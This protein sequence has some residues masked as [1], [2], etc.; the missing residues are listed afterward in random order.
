[1]F[2]IQFYPTPYAIAK[3][4][5]EPYDD[6]IKAGAVVLD[7]SAG[8][9]DLLK[10]AGYLIANDYR[11]K[12]ETKLL[13]VEIDPNLQAVLKQEKFRVIGDDWTKYS[14]HY[15]FDIV[16]MNPP[17]ADGAEHLLLAWERLTAGHIAC[18]LNAQTIKNT[19][20]SERQLLAQIIA[21]N[22][23]TVEYLG[24]CFSSAE[25]RTGVEVALVRLEKK[26]KG[27]FSF[28]GLK[29]G[30]EIDF[31]AIPDSVPARRDI[32]ESLVITFDQVAEALREH[33]QAE[34]KYR[35]LVGDLMTGFH[36]E[37]NEREAIENVKDPRDK[38]NLTLDTVRRGAWHQLFQRSQLRSIVT[39][40]VK[41]DFDAWNAQQGQAEFSRENILEFFVM[42]LVSRNQILHQCVTDVFDMMTR[43]DEKN[44]VHTEGWKTN[45][46]FRVNK[47]VILPHF[48]ECWNY[49]ANRR[50]LSV[51]HRAWDKA[52]DIDKAMCLVSGTQFEDIEERK[53]TLYE[54]LR[55][56]IHEN[57]ES[58]PGEGESEFFTFRYFIKGTVHIQFKDEF[59]WAEFNRRAAAGKGWL[60]D[61]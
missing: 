52:Q 4:M 39:E 56:A 21:D 14:G 43:F 20:T 46:S 49:A 55:R 15:H 40:R 24:D 10:A 13:A 9:G 34:T 41:K 42:L 61:G 59:V 57:G 1:M 51:N 37:K 18:L 44:R 8:K 16:L 11:T 35:M 19:H 47:K 22:G 32:A 31:D 23:G 7:P 12:R 25:R 33:I 6:L 53:A 50:Q 45:D 2:G 17:F 26:G 36:M 58:N 5:I 30:A 3:K 60:G 28:D 54:S 38:Y 29:G 48:V 27:Q